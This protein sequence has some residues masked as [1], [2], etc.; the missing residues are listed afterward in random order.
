MKSSLTEDEIEQY[1]LQLLQNLGYV[2]ITAMTSN[3]KA[4]TKS[5]KT[6]VK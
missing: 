4:K 5:A 3:P 6:S 1:Q 2:Y